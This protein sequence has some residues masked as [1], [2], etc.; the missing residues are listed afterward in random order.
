MNKDSLNPLYL[1]IKSDLLEKIN[2]G[3]YKPDDLLPTEEELHAQYNVSRATVR[4][5]LDE[6]ENEELIRRQRRVGTIVRHKKIKPELMKL[7]GF[8]NIMRSR[9]MKPRSK[10]INLEIV[11]TPKKVRELFKEPEAKKSWYIKRLLIADDK[12]I[13]LQDLYIPS[14]LNFSPEELL[15]IETKSFYGLLKEK[16]NINPILGNETIT[17]VNAGRNEAE[18]LQIKE[19]DALLDV[20]RSTFDDVIGVFEVCR[21]LYIADRYEYQVSLYP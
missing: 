16:H 4:H 2:L 21:I 14:R 6:M 9:G 13:G 1:Q 7:S 15:E 3:V 20:W 10:I 19:G 12:P 5:A 8:S 17:A 18:L 11:D